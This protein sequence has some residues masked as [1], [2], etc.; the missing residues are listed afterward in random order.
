MTAPVSC[1]RVLVAGVALAQYAGLALGAEPP[2]VRV[3]TSLDRT[4]V[5]VA[6]RVT[7]TVIVACN[8]GV[9]ILVDDLSRDKLRVEGLEILGAD[10]DRSTDR[11]EATTYRFN[12]YLT[13]YRVDQPA[14]KIA[15]M[16]VRYYV[17][18]PGQRLEDA[19]PA[20]EVQ[21]PAAV[22][23][24]RS[25]QPD[26]STTIDVRDGRPPTPRR[27][28]YT[29]LQPLGIALMLVSV[30]PAALF[31]ATMAARR[32][33]R[34]ATKSARQ[35]RHEERASL[36][37]VRALDLTAPEQRREAYSRLDALVRAHLRDTAGVPAPALT[38]GEIAS[39]LSA[40]SARVPL[41]LVSSV[42]AACDAARYAP[43]DLLPPSDVCR[44]AI[45]EAGQVLA[46]R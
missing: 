11:D 38:A 42:L 2:D 40:R 45:E 20:G 13:T 25:L 18:R 21:V 43:P 4:A 16:S 22:I 23:A 7:Y 34:A 17:K 44:R 31:A 30:V 26:E 24:F 12:Y 33:R 9:D 35:V 39:A 27:L 10:V 36:E 28:R 15:P 1:C 41:D 32:R 8:K 29:A 46:I 6:D 5:F 3:R 14:L 37:A 19:A